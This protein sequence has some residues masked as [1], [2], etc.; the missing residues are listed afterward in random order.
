[1]DN[2]E[3]AEAAAKADIAEPQKQRLNALRDAVAE[4]TRLLNP[5]SREAASSSR[6]AEPRAGN[7]RRRCRPHTKGRHKPRTETNPGRA[8]A[9]SR[10]RDHRDRRQRPARPP[11]WCGRTEPRRVSMAASAGLPLQLIGSRGKRSC[12]ARRRLGRL[13]GGEPGHCGRGQADHRRRRSGSHRSTCIRT[14]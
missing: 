13:Q 6:L 8:Q 2:I 7:L 3:Q 10:G 9:D 1:M 11:G 5:Q 14:S 4:A 12:A